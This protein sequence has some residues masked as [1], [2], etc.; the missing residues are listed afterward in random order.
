MT[1]NKPRYHCDQRV[2]W[3]G[4]A[5]E[6]NAHLQHGP[7]PFNTGLDKPDFLDGEFHYVLRTDPDGLRLDGTFRE[8]LLRKA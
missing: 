4:E 3:S 7:G 2:T 6:E 1:A 8:A 5:I